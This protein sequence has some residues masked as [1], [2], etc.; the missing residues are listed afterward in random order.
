MVNVVTFNYGCNHSGSRFCF[1]FFLFCLFRCFVH[2]IV[3]LWSCPLK[4]IVWTITLFFHVWNWW[5]HILTWYWWD[6]DRLLRIDSRQN[7]FYL[8]VTI[9]FFF[10][11][12]DWLWFLISIKLGNIGKQKIWYIHNLILILMKFD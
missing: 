2:S 8:M 10:A 1:C 12:V 4:L 9:I 6:R 5:I 3:L 11:V 7:I